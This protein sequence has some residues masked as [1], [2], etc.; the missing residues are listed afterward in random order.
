[1]MGRCPDMAILRKFGTLNMQ[2]LLY[3]QAEISQ[4]ESELI[5]LARDDI[6]QGNSGNRIKSWYTR[7][8]LPLSNYFGTTDDT[9]WRKMLQ[10]R[11]KLKE[12]SNYIVPS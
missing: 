2:N 4:L 11:G 10:I 5:R 7:N 8:W 1:M 12:Y 9:Q 3:L 6:N